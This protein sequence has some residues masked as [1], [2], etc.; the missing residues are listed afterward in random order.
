MRTVLTL[1]DEASKKCGGD[2]ALARRLGVARHHPIE[3]RKGLRPVTPV[4]VGKLCDVLELPGIEAQRLAAEA[5]ISSAQDSSLKE[6]LRR[7]FFGSW[8]A[9]GVAATLIGAPM[10]DATAGQ[11]TPLPSATSEGRSVYYVNWLRR[12][13]RAIL[14]RPRLFRVRRVMKSA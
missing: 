14:R 2:A 6:V 4:T 3:W 9:L 1:V 12:L 8:A 7:A 11:A 13:K 10:S 5:V